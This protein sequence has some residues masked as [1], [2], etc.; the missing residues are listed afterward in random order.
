MKL[1]VNIIVAIL[2]CSPGVSGA[3]CVQGD[4]TNGLG[5]AVLPHGGRYVGEFREGVR[6]GSGSMTYPDGAQY[7]GNWQNDKPHGKGRLFSAGKFEYTGEFSNGVRQGQGTLK[8]V[9]GKM[10]VGE[11]QDDVPHGQGTLSEPGKEEFTGQFVNGR[12]HGQGEALYPGGARYKG[13]WANDIPNGQGVKIMVD[14]M[15]FSG[16][17]RNG[18]MHGSGTVVLPDGN[19]LIVKWQ[20]ESPLQ[21]EDDQPETAVSDAACKRKWYMLA[22]PEKPL[23]P[24]SLGPAPSAGPMEVAP[25]AL[26]VGAEMPPRE[27]RLPAESPEEVPPR[28]P[29]KNEVAVVEKT[30]A[31][32]TGANR[33][34]E[35]EEIKPVSVE[36]GREKGNSEAGMALERYPETRQAGEF[37]SIAVGANIRSAA[38]LTAKVLRTVPAGYPVAVLEKQVKWF[39]VK[40]FRERKGWVFASLVSEP[41]TVIIRVFKGNLRKG[42][43]IQDEIIAQL[44][45]GTIMSVMKRNGEWLKVTDSAELTGWLHREV[46][47]P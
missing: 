1:T 36:P 32:T 7:D 38:S 31:D 39:L 18:F 25:Q 33:P 26:A 30:Q 35:S 43:D 40:D 29:E 22:T 27:S 16:E 13:E 45:F 34:A 21:K 11:W 12:R 9:G 46:I 19:K 5:T 20:A 44:D 23:K 3:A 10:Y 47:W 15:Q 8:V 6:K 4:C 28:I 17:F 24:F 2:M 14:G 41:G 42:P 37:A